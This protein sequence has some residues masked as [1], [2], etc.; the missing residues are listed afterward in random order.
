MN[1]AIS[2]IYGPLLKSTAATCQ[3]RD[4][5]KDKV[6]SESHKNPIKSEPES[7][8]KEVRANDEKIII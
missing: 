7:L 3:I 1:K 8:K 4:L 6:N 2:L 5:K